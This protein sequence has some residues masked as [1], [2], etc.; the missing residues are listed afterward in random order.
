MSSYR[1]IE[2]ISNPVLNQTVT[3]L[4]PIVSDFINCTSMAS[5]CFQIKYGATLNATFQIL[6]SLD[7]V[8]YS[9]LNAVIAPATGSAGSTMG[10]ID[11]G[12][13]KYVLLQISPTSGSATVT[14]LARAATRP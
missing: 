10:N 3:G 14:I 5:V 1:E 11:C 13:V 4:A 7:G 12:A 8:I 6:G 9:D 2:R